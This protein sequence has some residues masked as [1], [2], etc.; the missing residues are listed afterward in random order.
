MEKEQEAQKYADLRDRAAALE[1]ALR[2][3]FR[4]LRNRGDGI[5]EL[6]AEFDGLLTREE[7]ENVERR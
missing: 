3:A 1:A 5:D 6:E 2:H 4:L 7:I